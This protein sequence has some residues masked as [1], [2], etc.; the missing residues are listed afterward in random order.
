MGLSSGFPIPL[1]MSASS[2]TSIELSSD[3]D[4]IAARR[5]RAN[6]Q[7]MQR[8]TTHSLVQHKFQL[9]ALFFHRNSA[10]LYNLVESGRNHAAGKRI[11]ER[12]QSSGWL[13]KTGGV[14]QR[15]AP[16]RCCLQPGGGT[17]V[18]ALASLLLGHFWLRGMVFWPRIGVVWWLC[19]GRAR[20]P[21]C[22]SR[23]PFTCTDG[24]PRR[25]GCLCMHEASSVRK[26]GRSCQI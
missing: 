8:E 4:V 17:V 16:R 10:P 7:P 3:D 24:S 18:V 23:P 14:S 20:A 11:A 19:P 12:N 13:Q 22:R 25:E 9:I 15:R 21:G 26:I 1:C 2:I 5:P 6:A